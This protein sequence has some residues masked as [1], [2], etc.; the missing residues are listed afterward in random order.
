MPEF[1][2]HH[3]EALDVLRT[4]PDA[5]VD[6]IIT[7]PPYCAGAI[8]E[9]QRTR[10]IGQ[11]LRSEN[12][13]RFGWFTGDNMGTAGLA[14]LLRSLAVE[15]S[16]VVRDTGSFL[17]FCDWR[18]QSALQPAIESA[19][20]RYQGLI[21]WD[22]ESFGMG[23]GFRCQHELILHFTYGNPEYYD[24]A[25]ANVI[26]SSR[27]P[28]DDREHQTQKPTDLIARLARVVS[29]DTGTVLDPFMGSGT[30]GVACMNTGRNFIGIEIDEGY[31]N[32]AKRRIEAAAAQLKLFVA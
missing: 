1:T 23:N 10:A 25:T 15:S 32:I 31:F 27:I 17:V 21:V 6:C 18:M 8:S 30:T 9:A 22:K 24:R 20:L 2:L 26:R 16:R 5:S 19:G 4:M 7:D 12:L 11:G 28:K 3:G 14:W 13:R 29:P